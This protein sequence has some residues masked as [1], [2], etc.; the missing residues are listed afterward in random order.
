MHPEIMKYLETILPLLKKNDYILSDEKPI[1]YGVQLR[2]SKQ[3]E[4]IPLNIYYSAKKGISKVIGGSPKSK[5]R[6]Q[7]EILLR[8]PA[9]GE[10]VELAHKWNTWIGT[11]ESGKGDFFGPLICAGFYGERK[12]IPYLRQIGVDDSKKLRDNDIDKIARQL[13]GAYF[14][15]IKVITML[16]ATYNKRYQ[17][18]KSRGK[19][20]NDLLA[21]MHTRIIVDL[22]QQYHPQGVL[23]DKFTSDYKIKTALKEMAQIPFL[24]QIKSESD[25]FVAAASIIARFHFN[26]WFKKQKAERGITLIK[27]AGKK[28]DE[29]AVDLVQKIGIKELSS[30]VKMHFKN[31]QKL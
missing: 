26:N 10:T 30:L 6:N 3:G 20:L 22:F 5:L 13:Y 9:T 7:L 24:N 31:Y 15:N 18:L 19:N 27:G 8:L 4:I 23:I 2:F 28:V 16:P 14:D 17:D 12:I 25:P 21:W 11:D 1:N 29:T